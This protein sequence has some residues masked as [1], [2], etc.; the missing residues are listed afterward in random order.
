[1][2]PLTTTER[3]GR[4]PSAVVRRSR[5]DGHRSSVAQT[6]C[7]ACLFGAPPRARPRRRPP[8]SR[9]PRNATASCRPRRSRRR[10]PSAT[11][12]RSMRLPRRLRPRRVLPR[13]RDTR[14]RSPAPCRARARVTS[15]STARRPFSSAAAFTREGGAERAPDR[16]QEQKR[17]ED[18]RHDAERDGRAR[19]R[20]RGTGTLSKRCTARSIVMSFSM[21]QT[22]M[23]QV[24]AR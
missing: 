16:Q 8:P 11:S 20:P 22:P 10:P 18:E 15:R 2:S 23:K 7:L 24:E 4:F 13:L 5:R 17:R 14:R 3:A 12:S 21:A 9:G 6:T 1:M 19:S